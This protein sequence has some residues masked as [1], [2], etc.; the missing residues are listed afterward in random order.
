[1][2]SEADYL[3]CGLLWACGKLDENGQSTKDYGPSK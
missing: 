2:E 1:M 3:T